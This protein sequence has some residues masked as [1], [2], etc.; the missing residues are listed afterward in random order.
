MNREKVAADATRK[1]KTT[2]NTDSA[3]SLGTTRLAT[4]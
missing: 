1:T 2:S 4:S 3:I